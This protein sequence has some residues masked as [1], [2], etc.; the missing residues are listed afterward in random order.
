MEHSLYSFSSSARWI[1]GACPASI[2]KSKGKKSVENDAARLGTAAHE[3]REFC[4]KFGVEPNECLGNEIDKFTVDH[5]MA[6]AVSLDV[7]YCRKLAIEYNTKYLIEQRVYM[8]NRDDVFGTA[9]TIFLVPHLRRMHI[10]DYKH[11]FGIVEVA[12]NTQLIAYAIASLDTYDQWDAV[13]EVLTTI[14]QPRANHIDG[15]IRT[16]TYTVDKLREW[17]ELF[18]RSIAAVENPKTTPKAGDYCKFCLAQATCKARMMQVLNVAYHNENDDQI[19]ISMLETIYREKASI[20][21]YLDAVEK[22]IV[23]LA[24]N[25]QKIDGYKVVDSRPRAV[26]TDEKN[27]RQEALAHGVDVERLY[28]KRLKSEWSAKQVLPESLIKKYYIKPEPVPTLVP[29]TDK[30]PAKSARSASNVFE[31][32]KDIKNGE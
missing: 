19:P 10:V 15:S 30:R 21:K 32:V 3:L 2:R 4:L 16:Y 31:P 18:S 14:V 27:L 20:E 22:E 23:R 17:K 26:V 25:G 28:D 11:G 7:N 29:L 13:D 8:F 12:D 24:I 9:D 1:E 5:D 6:N